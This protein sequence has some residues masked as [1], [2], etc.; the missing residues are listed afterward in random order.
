M[1]E[2]LEIRNIRTDGGTQPRA[3]IAIA[4]DTRDALQEAMKQ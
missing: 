4:E 3:G 1:P 2:N